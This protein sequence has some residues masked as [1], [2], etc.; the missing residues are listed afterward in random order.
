MLAA[1]RRNYRAGMRFRL[2]P[3][4]LGRTDSNTLAAPATIRSAP[5]RASRG[6]QATQE[7]L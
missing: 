7:L 3:Y 1:G 2:V 4:G 6:W 5:R